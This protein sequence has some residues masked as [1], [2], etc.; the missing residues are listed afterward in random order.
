MNDLDPQLFSSIETNTPLVSI[1]LVNANRRCEV[2][3]GQRTNR[4][5]QRM[6]FVPGGRI[7][8]DESIA[9]AFKQLMHTEVGREIDMQQGEFMGGYE[10]FYPD[11]FFGDRAMTTG[12]ARAL[13][14]V[15]ARRAVA[16]G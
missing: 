9:D 7:L 2:L 10:Y 16:V 1:D 14:L 3:L 4:F 12:A 15:D 13:Q 5:G 8:K 6:W 11:N